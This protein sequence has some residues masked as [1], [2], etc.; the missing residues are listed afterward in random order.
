MEAELPELRHLREFT[1]KVLVAIVWVHVP[2]AILIAAARGSEMFAPVIFA[3][4]MSIST[5][6][7]K[8][9]GNGVST[10]LV[11]AVALMAD[12]AL[13]TYQLSG[14]PWQS[15]MHMY[16]FS[17]LACLVAYCDY[18]PILFGALAVSLHHLLLNFILPAA[19]YPGGSDI[20]R[21]FFH[22][23]VLLIEASVLCWLSV[24]LSHFLTEADVKRSEAKRANEAERLAS[25]ERANA[26]VKAKRQGELVRR[27]LADEFQEQIARIV[28]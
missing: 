10:R 18:R 1:S 26:E 2:I 21:A 28:E 19:V 4:A 12:V 7:W 8:I 9:D 13:F 20:A 25:E 15:D 27:E 23:A 17:L 6:C 14:H 11:F 5:A 3:V 22:A 24:K 16:F